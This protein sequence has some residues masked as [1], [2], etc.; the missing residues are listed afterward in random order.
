MYLIT[1]QFHFSAA[2]RLDHLPST[3]PCARDHGHNYLVELVLG[4]G[5]L[6]ERGFVRDYT[7]L[8]AFES[9]LDHE[10]DH[11]H[12]N[13]VLAFPPTAENIASYLYRRSKECWPEVV[14]VRVGETPRTWAEFREADA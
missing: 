10:L 2:H 6:D 12:L 9:L 1:K 7:E 11:R 5:A 13:D 3:H 8:A 14:A 4:A